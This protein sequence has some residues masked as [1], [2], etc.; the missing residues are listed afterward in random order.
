MPRRV[1]AENKRGARWTVALTA[2][3]SQAV[4][5]VAAAHNTRPGP[6]IRARALPSIRRE[7]ARL[8]RTLGPLL[9]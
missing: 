9:E 5:L 3:E 6:L 2:G 8:H 4:E 7:A 1:A